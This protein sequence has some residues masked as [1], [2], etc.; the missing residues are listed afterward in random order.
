MVIVKI[1]EG[2][3]NQLFQYAFARSLELRTGQRVFIDIENRDKHERGARTNR[4]YQLHH[5]RIRQNM[6]CNVIQK[7]IARICNTDELAVLLRYLSDKGI[8][9]IQLYEEKTL[10]FKPELFHTKG[11]VYLEGW[12]QNES[13]F[14]EYR[15]IIMR[16]LCPKRKI[17]I[18]T[19]I[20]QIMRERETV[21][22]HIR[23]GDY[24]KYG[25]VLPMSYYTNA[26]A[27]IK[28][29]VTK[30]YFLV[31]SDEPKWVSQNLILNEDSLIISA[32]QKLQD[33]EE[34]FL[35]SSCKHNIIANSTFSWWAAWLNNHEDKIVI[36]PE[37]WFKDNT[38]NAGINI[39]PDDWIKVN[40]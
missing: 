35:M 13:Y 40:V 3:G 23:R 32:E 39:M 26:I 7:M 11:I 28:E 14:A 18:S 2:L 19:K 36:G 29:R 17:K 16:E 22:L 21:S 31:F 20:R 25:Y 34:L 4:T 8:S 15:N 6:Y 9:V 24:K 5:M 38:V 37:K 12:F 33:Y 1:W 30:P 27:Y 10:E